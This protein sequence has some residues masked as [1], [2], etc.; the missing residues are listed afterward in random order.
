MATLRLWGIPARRHPR[1]TGRSARRT[2]RAPPRTHTRRGT[3]ATLRRSNAR[4]DAPPHLPHRPAV[5]SSPGRAGIAPAASTVTTANKRPGR[6]RPDRGG[7]AHP[8]PLPSRACMSFLSTRR[9]TCPITP[10]SFCLSR[11]FVRRCSGALGRTRPRSR[12]TPSPRVLAL[13]TSSYLVCTA[14]GKERESRGE[15]AL[16]GTFGRA[17]DSWS[18]SKGR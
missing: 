1:D 5:S 9:A 6:V 17:I 16:P 11:R 4:N 2:Q 18:K 8:G 12:F 7:S 13:P 3:A 15:K 10:R 14:C